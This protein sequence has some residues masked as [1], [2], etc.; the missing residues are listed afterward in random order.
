MIRIEDYNFGLDRNETVWFGYK[1]RNNS[2][3]FGLVQNEFQSEITFAREETIKNGKNSRFRQIYV[4]F[5]LKRYL[6]SLT[7][8]LMLKM[9]NSK[10]RNQYGS[11]NFKIFIYSFEAFGIYLVYKGVVFGPLNSILM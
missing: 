8:N 2:E 9:Q 10:W 7:S 5:G 4:K 11:R 3:N 6:G 1:F